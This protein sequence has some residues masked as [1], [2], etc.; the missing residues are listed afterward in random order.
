LLSDKTVSV[1]EFLRTRRLG[2]VRAGI[3]IEE[4]LAHWGTPT[5]EHLSR[6]PAI[7][8]GPVYLF[9]GAERVLYLAIYPWRSMGQGPPGFALDVPVTNASEFRLALTSVGL[10]LTQADDL[11]AAGESNV[12][13]RIEESHVEVIFD[14][15]GRV[16]AL[17]EP[18]KEPP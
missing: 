6:P 4:V 14:D 18:R 8:Y 3:S 12:P 11:A 17:V 16:S 13:L 1:L 15:T 10:H 7:S 2:P 5:E 9:V